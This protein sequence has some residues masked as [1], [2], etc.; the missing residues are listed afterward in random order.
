MFNSG[1]RP[2][3]DSGLSVSRVG[4]SAQIKAMKKVSGS[5]KLQLAQYREMLSFAQ[6][7]SDLD[8]ATKAVLD[9]GERL[10]ELLKQD[11]YSPMT[12]EHQV[13]SL[14]AA[15][16]G[17]L[18]NIPVSMVK[19]YEKDMLSYMD[20]NHKDLMKEL[21]ETQVLSDDLT[22]RFIKAL[23]DYTRQFEMTVGA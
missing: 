21:A 22:N 16:N 12:V 15:N 9:H 3:V 4:S 8:A 2:A 5:L 10:T 11:Q 23:T 13:V 17:C 18:K 14:L 6:F 7:G 19:K 20:V 1:V